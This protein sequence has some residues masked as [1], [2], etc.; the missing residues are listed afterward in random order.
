MLVLPLWIEAIPEDS[1]R[2]EMERLFREHQKLMMATAGCFAQQSCDA[3]EIVSESLMALYGKLD[4]IRDMDQN[5]LRPYIVSTVRNTALNYL[6]KMRRMNVRFLHL[7]DMAIDQM[8]GGE[9]PERKIL[10]SEELDRVRMAIRALPERERM[11]IQLRYEMD[12]T[13][14]EIAAIMG[15]GADSVRRYI[16]RGRSR[17]KRMLYQE[18][19]DDE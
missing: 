10:L 6:K 13:D 19:N 17:I 7:P 16:H 14:A 11:A 15:I 3:D 4:K 2:E 12:Q 8:P 18:E 5:A 9:N 1:D